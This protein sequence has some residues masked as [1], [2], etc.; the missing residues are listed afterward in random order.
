M[1]TG[2]SFESVI[3]NDIIQKLYAFS[4]KWPISSMYL[5]SYLLLLLSLFLFV[6]NVSTIHSIEHSE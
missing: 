4:F 1:L 5:I 2:V 6:L 3:S